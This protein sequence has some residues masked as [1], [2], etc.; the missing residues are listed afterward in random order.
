MFDFTAN[1]NF[2]CH[3]SEDVLCV[4]GFEFIE[5]KVIHTVLLCQPRKCHCWPGAIRK[6]FGR[7]LNTLF[8]FTQIDV[9]YRCDKRWPITALDRDIKNWNFELSR[10][11]SQ[12]DGIFRVRTIWISF[13][14]WNPV[15]FPKV[16]GM[17]YCTAPSIISLSLIFVGTDFRNLLVGEIR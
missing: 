5:N 15:P 16:Q 2:I 11:N 1:S 14:P 17:S 12:N 6:T 4:K 8:A 10:R 9:N 13:N 7:R 3:H